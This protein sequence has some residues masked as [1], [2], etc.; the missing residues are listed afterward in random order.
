VWWVGWRETA[1]SFGEA[2]FV[3]KSFFCPRCSL[4]LILVDPKPKLDEK[5]WNEKSWENRC[6]AP[7]IGMAGEPYCALTGERLWPR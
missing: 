6:Y 5:E 3:E 4:A 2:H 7:K 1:I